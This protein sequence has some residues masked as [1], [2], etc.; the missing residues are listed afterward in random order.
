MSLDPSQHALH[1]LLDELN[2][3]EEER[4]RGLLVGGLSGD[5]WTAWSE[6]QRTAL[7][8]LQSVPDDAD[9]RIIQRVAREITRRWGPRLRTRIKG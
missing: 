1:A 4:R 3:L 6:R 8:K 9:G 5:A 7:E 2:A